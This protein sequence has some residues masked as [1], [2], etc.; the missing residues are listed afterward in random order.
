MLVLVFFVFDP[1]LSLVESFNHGHLA[2]Y[3][4]VKLRAEVVDVVELEPYERVNVVLLK[5]SWRHVM[6]SFAEAQYV[7]GLQIFKDL[8][9][10]DR[11]G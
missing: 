11:L 6:V 3:V 1:L 2:S 10:F 8:A 5:L 4:V 9:D 7:L